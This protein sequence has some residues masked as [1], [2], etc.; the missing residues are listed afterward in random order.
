MAS[1][2][3]Y[4]QR[5]AH[6]QEQVKQ[7]D[8]T[9]RYY[10]IS[11]IVVTLVTIALAYLGF[12]ESLFFY[13]I[14][15]SFILFFFLVQRQSKKEEDRRILLHLVK[16]NQWEGSATLYDFHNFPDGQ[17]FVNSHHSYS[18]D[19]DLFGK[20]SLFQYL[21]RS[22]TQLGETK[23]ADEL[24]HLKFGKEEVLQRQQAIRALGPM[25][26]FR[27]QCWAIGKEIHDKDFNLEPLWLWARAA[28]LFHGKKLFLVLQWVLPA[29]TCLSLLAIA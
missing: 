25:V 10:S 26:E 5:V 23:L 13:P 4:Q 9:I 24:A 18:H 27:Q 1:A 6:F 21:N 7:V 16:L 11:R 8:K 29:I 14:P 19:L 3:F 20:G 15:L 28:S 22:A 17:S 2:E 12:Q